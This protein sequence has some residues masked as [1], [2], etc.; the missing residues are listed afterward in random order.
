MRGVDTDTSAAFDL[1]TSA[2]DLPQPPAGVPPLI[3][4]NA[5]TIAALGGPPLR[6]AQI[7]RRISPP[8]PAAAAPAAGPAPAIALPATFGGPAVGS[9]LATQ[10][11]TV[12]GLFNAAITAIAGVEAQAPALLAAIASQADL[13]KAGLGFDG[14][15]AADFSA[16]LSTALDTIRPA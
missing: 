5:A 16:A 14:Q 4:S 8:A 3:P 7:R 6:M 11:Q 9:E 13:A 10:V 1:E 12:R 2:P 15:E